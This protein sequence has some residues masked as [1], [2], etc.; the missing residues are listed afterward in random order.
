MNQTLTEYST[1]L[2]DLENLIK[3]NKKSASA[4][5]YPKGN[6]PPDAKGQYHFIFNHKLNSYFTIQFKGIKVSYAY[7]KNH[8]YP[9][10]GACTIEEMKLL[11][12]SWLIS[13]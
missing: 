1:T 2:T 13:L 4:F 12:N 10:I 9:T 8:R 7:S 3:A 11:F 5:T 6:D